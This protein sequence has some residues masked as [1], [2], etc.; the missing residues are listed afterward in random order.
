[1]RSF[2]SKM[3]GQNLTHTHPQ[4]GHVHSMFNL[5]ANK[6]TI[7]HHEIAI[8]HS[9]SQLISHKSPVLNMWPVGLWSKVQ[10]STCRRGLACFFQVSV[11][12]TDPL[13]LQLCTV[14]QSQLLGGLWLAWYSVSTCFFLHS[15]KWDNTRS[16]TWFLHLAESYHQGP[17]W[18][19]P[20]LCCSSPYNPM[21]YIVTHVTSV[22]E[23][24][25]E[26]T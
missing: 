1:M 16:G 7:N 22:S 19:V 2:T 14:A 18:N 26:F 6:T 13:L 5:F 21:I 17:S 4:P 11:S 8:H 10:R 25:T 3:T 15:Y 20:W 24:R 23:V 9:E 12:W